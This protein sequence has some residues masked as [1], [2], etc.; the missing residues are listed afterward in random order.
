MHYLN[1][2]KPKKVR[3]Q[4][5][6]E[7]W[8]EKKL[9]TGRDGDGCD[10]QSTPEA[11]EMERSGFRKSDWE[12]ELR[13]DDMPVQLQYPSNPSSK[14]ARDRARDIPAIIELEQNFCSD[15]TYTF[16]MEQVLL[17]ELRVQIR[18]RQKMLNEDYR[19]SMIRLTNSAKA[20]AEYD[21]AKEMISSNR[22]KS[23]E[24]FESMNQNVFERL[25][26]ENERRR[27]NRKDRF[28]HALISILYNDRALRLY[29][30]HC[31]KNRV[32]PDRKLVKKLNVYHR[33]SRFDKDAIGHNEKEDDTTLDFPRGTFVLQQQKAVLAILSN[34][35]NLT[36]VSIRDPIDNTVVN[37]FIDELIG[38]DNLEKLELVG[39]LK[40]ISGFKS[41]REYSEAASN[42]GNNLGKIY[43]N[44]SERKKL[45]T[46]YDIKLTSHVNK[47]RESKARNVVK[48]FQKF[49]KFKHLKYLD[50]S[51]NNI[52]DQG[53]QGLVSTGVGKVVICR[54]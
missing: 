36:H 31:N 12:F 5:L 8:M 32:H 21:T 35:N 11:E 29:F 6:R 30:Q 19:S 46:K 48:F 18:E 27:R 52:G 43:K 16:Q 25:E 50:L 45:L 41:K 15:E 42:V 4:G 40:D 34:L 20:G 14:L 22:L 23:M 53:L 44:K 51:C 38:L 3:L 10:D 1:R 33:M 2:E 28:L 54:F 17:E 24:V 47:H 37:D 26:E 7:I 9:V 49:Q 13:F 39:A